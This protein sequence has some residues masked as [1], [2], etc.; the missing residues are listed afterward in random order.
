MM[1]ESAISNLPPLYQDPAA[2]TAKRHGKL[3][4]P[5]QPDFR[6]AAKAVAVP[7]LLAEFPFLVRHYPIVFAE[8]GE[9]HP[10]AIMGVANGINLFI[11]AQGRFQNDCYIP[12][13][14]RRYP[15][16]LA[17]T[18]DRA[19]STLCIDEAAP[20]LAPKQE[21]KLFENGQPT[22]FVQEALNLCTGFATEFERTR[23][24]VA[25]LSTMNLLSPQKAEVA[26]PDKSPWMIQGFRG[27]DQEA[28]AKLD[29]VQL[30]GLRDAG[31]L[32]AIYL[33]IASQNNWLSL[34]GRQEKIAEPKPIVH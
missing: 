33:Q 13:Y 22:A 5:E 8:G 30:L 16:I 29:G 25:K 23:L 21:K 12:A 27:T 19:G 1:P 28:L 11:D 24:A 9:A 2:L 4:L 20:Q 15:F 18:T 17:D 10:L 34:L 32:S 6:F 31:L 14:L 7:V 3:T 26:M